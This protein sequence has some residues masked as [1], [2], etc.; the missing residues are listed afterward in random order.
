MTKQID[1]CSLFTDLIDELRQWFLL[2]ENRIYQH[3]EKGFVQT[4]FG[5]LTY[6]KARVGF[7]NIH[8]DRMA[9]MKRAHGALWLQIYQPC[10]L[11][12]TNYRRGVVIIDT[13]IYLSTM[14]TALTGL[15]Y[16]PLSISIFRSL[17]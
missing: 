11:D 2:E 17:K 13:S 5:Y 14:F 3:R 7:Y 8:F 10:V 12:N 9:E 16:D 4:P 15:L 1:M 6:N